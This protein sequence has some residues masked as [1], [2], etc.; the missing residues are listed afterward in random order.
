[1]NFRFVPLCVLAFLIAFSGIN[2]TS[3]HPATFDD[4]DIATFYRGKVV[5]MI[6]GFPPGGGADAYT[7]LIAG[8]LG[9][10]I[11]GNPTLAV[12][13]MPGAGSMIAGNYVFNKGAKDGTEIGMLN[14]AVILEQ[15]FQNPG[16]RF[17]M[18]KFRYLAVPVKETYV[19]IVARRSGIVKFSDLLE[20]DTKPLVLGAIPNST[21]EHAPLLL[22]EA[23]GAK[24]KIVSG[25]KGSADI[26]LAMDSGEIEGF[27]N[28]WSTL[29]ITA[30]EKLQTGE[31]LVI[32]Q[33]DNQP[34]TDLPTS[35]IPTIPQL[36]KDE[37]DR[38]LLYYGT[39][40]PNQFGKVYMLPPGVAPAVTAAL[41]AGFVKTLRD[42]TFLAD[43]KKSKLEITPIF[44]AAI[45]TIVDD[46]LN[47]PPAIKEK[48]RRTIKK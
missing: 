29:K 44:G 42:K 43:A 34:L 19:M 45:H 8:H 15:L 40:A 31:W 22:R 39:S 5:R 32:A 37:N 25:Y 46:F 7:R 18:A 4:R 13:N 6:V 14:G 47:M 27:F 2:S 33:L 11:P 1:M 35:G 24:L 30:E 21:L 10:F 38:A 26:R 17:D 23:L 48:L 41:E 36:T 16:V 28:P 3:A 20:R 12:N 9:R